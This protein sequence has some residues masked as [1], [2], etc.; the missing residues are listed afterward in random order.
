MSRINNARQV[1][2]LEKL[3]HTRPSSTNINSWSRKWQ[4]QDVPLPHWW[5]ES[6]RC[7]PHEAEEDKLLEETSEK[8]GEDEDMRTDVGREKKILKKRIKKGNKNLLC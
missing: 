4:T 2:L 1:C 3:N 8:H 7:P 5:A 6:S